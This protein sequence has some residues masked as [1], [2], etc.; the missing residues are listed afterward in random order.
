M[1]SI[2]VSIAQANS[3]L[4]ISLKAYVHIRH[5]HL[6]NRSIPSCYTSTAALMTVTVVSMM[7][8]N[9][10]AMPIN[11]INYNCHK[12]YNSCRTCLTN[13]YHATSY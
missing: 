1:F 10:K 9:A 3:T 12:N 7:R 13:P 4:R 2:Y 11:D 8:I 6:Y 5:T